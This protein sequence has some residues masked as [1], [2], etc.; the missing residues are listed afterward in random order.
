[1]LMKEINY[2]FFSHN[3]QFLN[4]QGLKTNL[5]WTRQSML[6]Q[7]VV[8]Q[9]PKNLIHFFLKGYKYT[10]KTLSKIYLTLTFNY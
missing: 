6:L 7:N 8:T 1:M 3:N 2:R 9:T 10:F 4:I 5:T